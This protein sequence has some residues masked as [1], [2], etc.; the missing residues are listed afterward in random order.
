MGVDAPVAIRLARTDELPAVSN[1]LDG[2]LLEVN[3]D[4]ER[5][6]CLVGSGHVHALR[7]LLLETPE[8]CPT[9]ALPY[10]PREE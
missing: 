3:G 8:F 7:Q 4:T 1:V 6:L 5:I 9:S 2:G 10:L